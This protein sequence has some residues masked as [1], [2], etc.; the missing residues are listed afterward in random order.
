MNIGT[1]NRDI[2][3][4]YI[5]DSRNTDPGKEFHSFEVRIMNEEAKRF[6]ML[7]GGIS[8]TVEARPAFG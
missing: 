2:H 1:E 3:S 8:T 4:P 7:K 5:K 6:V